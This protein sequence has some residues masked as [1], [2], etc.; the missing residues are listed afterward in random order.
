[1][2]N[3]ETISQWSIAGGPVFQFND[4]YLE[5]C[6]IEWQFKIRY[7]DI[8]GPGHY[9]RVQ[10]KDRLVIATFFYLIFLAWILVYREHF[11]YY[12]M[13]GLQWFE[14]PVIALVAV[15]TVVCGPLYYLTHKRL[16]L[17]PTMSGN[18]FV[19]LD[20]QHDAIIEKIQVA[21]LSKLRQLSAPEP[22]NS[23]DEELAKLEF[24]RQEGAISDDECVRLAS[25]LRASPR[26]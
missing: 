10:T 12:A 3:T 24:L 9:R 2:P 11:P 25:Q 17:I 22:Q 6:G 5:Y 14:A 7:E 4:S 16:T 15:V 13:E 19:V 20:R 18:I 1:M 8:L 26:N 21:R 23:T